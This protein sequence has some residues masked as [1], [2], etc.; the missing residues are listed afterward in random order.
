[1]G[2]GFGFG[3]AMFAMKNLTADYE[4]AGSIPSQPVQMQIS[5]NPQSSFK[6]APT[7][8]PPL[9]APSQPKITSFNKGS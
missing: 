2:L 1:M 6:P 5:K 9:T 7:I 4:Q 8:K 3:D